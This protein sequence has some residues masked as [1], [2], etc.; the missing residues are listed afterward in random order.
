MIVS[1]DEVDAHFVGMPP[2][3]WDRVTEDELVWGLQTVHRFFSRLAITPA[4][5]GVVVMDARHFPQ[6]GCT[7]VLV[8]TWDRMGLLTRIAGYLSAL[9]LTG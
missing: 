9:R 7:K 4:S 2:R 5:D 3:Y 1:Q 6:Q 8:S